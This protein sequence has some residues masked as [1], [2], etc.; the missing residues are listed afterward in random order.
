[1]TAL[2]RCNL[3]DLWSL[4]TWN[5]PCVDIK[6]YSLM[7]IFNVAV[8]EEGAQVKVWEGWVSPLAKRRHYHDILVAKWHYFKLNGELED[9]TWYGSCPWLQASSTHLKT[10][11]IFLLCVQVC[12][13]IKHKINLISTKEGHKVPGSNLSMWSLYF[14]DSFLP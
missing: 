8:S 11:T 5:R 7:V 1:M 14:H 9:W 3:S 12:S 6:Y 10:L 13:E 4:C 2:K